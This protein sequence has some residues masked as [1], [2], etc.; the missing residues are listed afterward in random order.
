MSKKLPQ[1]K[2]VMI[3][4]LKFSSTRLKNLKTK[5]SCYPKRICSWSSSRRSR[6]ILR[7]RR[8]YC[9]ESRNLTSRIR[10]WL[11]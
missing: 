6:V 1:F 4:K 7:K 3:T 8:R 2:A 11:L 9:W 10:Y 5:I